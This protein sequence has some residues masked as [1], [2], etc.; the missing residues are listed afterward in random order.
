MVVAL[1]DVPEA[2]DHESEKEEQ[3]SGAPHRPRQSPLLS[4][5]GAEGMEEKIV[6]HLIKKNRHRGNKDLSGEGGV[7]VQN[8]LQIGVC[9]WSTYSGEEWLRLDVYTNESFLLQLKKNA[10]QTKFTGVPSPDGPQGQ[11]RTLG[12]GGL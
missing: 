1:Q 8:I 10:S 12:F 3:V 4:G 5:C 7:Y 9:N 11:V 2:L 6:N